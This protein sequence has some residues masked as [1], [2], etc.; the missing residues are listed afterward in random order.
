MMQVNA[1]DIFKEQFDEI[2]AIYPNFYLKDDIDSFSLLGQFELIDCDGI[3][4]DSYDIE[5][6]PTSE[7]PFEF[8]LVFEKS[9]KIPVNIDW[10]TYADGHFCIKTIPEEKITCKHGI[11]LKYFFKSEIKPYL[12]NQTF[13]RLN[14]YFLN[15]RSHGIIG[16]IEFYQTL[17]KES[18]L[19]KIIDMMLFVLAEK[20]PSRT[21]KCFC[22]KKSKYRKCHRESFQKLNMLSTEEIFVLIRRVVF[23]DYMYTLNP[24][25]TIRIRKLFQK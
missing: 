13:R 22:G 17:F 14:G 4:Q 16:E 18:N 25:E 24:V 20:E 3:K 9:G 10:H 2:S 11:T 7:F 8:P 12:F 23:S 5:I 1:K 21:E 6:V 19:P 15:E